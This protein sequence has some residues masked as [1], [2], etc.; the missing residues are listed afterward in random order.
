MSLGPDTEVI[1]GQRF[2]LPQGNVFFP[3]AFGPQTQGV[4]NVSPTMPAF[5]GGSP[6]AGGFSSVNGYGTAENN[7]TVTA[8]AAANPF[9]WKVS[10]V[11]WAV[12]GLVVSLL[13]I[14]KIHWRKTILEGEEHVGI[15]GAREEASAAA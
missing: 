2:K 12:V 1:N 9:N 7:S 6:S 10:P 4:P 3:T 11:L 5:L 15:G 14:Q 8:V 13:L